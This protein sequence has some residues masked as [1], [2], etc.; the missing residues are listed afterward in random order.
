MKYKN[1]E[2]Y[3][4]VEVTEYYY[5]ETNARMDNIPCY[6]SSLLDGGDFLHKSDRKEL[7]VS[8]ITL[9]SND[10][11][12]NVVKAIASKVPS[13][14]EH[15]GRWKVIWEHA[16]Y[17][18][19]YGYNIPVVPLEIQL[20]SNIRRNRQDRREAIITALK[21][22]GYNK[23]LLNKALSKTNIEYVKAIL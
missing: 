18:Y 19:F 15:L 22:I 13:T 14:D 7:K 8:D 20:E 3:F 2:T 11:T 6:S 1:E 23:K 4:G 5:N 21:T 9:I 17:V 12:E 16:R 10:G